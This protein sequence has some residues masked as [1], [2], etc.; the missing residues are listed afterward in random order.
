MLYDGA[1]ELRSGKVR[2]DARP[3]TSAGSL[4]SSPGFQSTT[5]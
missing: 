2:V 3:A 5:A 4:V 1:N